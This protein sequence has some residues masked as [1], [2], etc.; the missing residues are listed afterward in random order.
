MLP[1]HFGGFHI[2]FVGNLIKFVSV[3]LR[4]QINEL[5]S[6]I[7]WGLNNNAAAKLAWYCFSQ[8]QLCLPDSDVTSLAS[9]ATAP[10]KPQQKLSDAYSDKVIVSLDFRDMI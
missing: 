9:C 10:L 5:Q 3:A 6:Y 4:T 7:M 2:D 8:L 1:L